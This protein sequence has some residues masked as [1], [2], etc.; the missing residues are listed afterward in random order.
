[1]AKTATSQVL[2]ISDTNWAGVMVPVASQRAGIDLIIDTLIKAAKPPLSSGTG[3]FASW[4]PGLRSGK[5]WDNGWC[6]ECDGYS[7]R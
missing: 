6:D 7:G 3:W 4:K 5:Q 1:M 2:P